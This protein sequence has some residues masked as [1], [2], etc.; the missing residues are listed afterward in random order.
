M[1]DVRGA[2]RAASAP[3]S[4]HAGTG[5]LFT[6]SLPLEVGKYPKDRRADFQQ[7]GGG[8]DNTAV[9]FK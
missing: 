5:V 9:H 4:V 7:Q 3:V 6:V 2:N 1:Q 8:I